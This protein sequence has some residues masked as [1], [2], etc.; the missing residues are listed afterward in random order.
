MNS[1]LLIL[2]EGLMAACFTFLADFYHNNN[3]RVD[4]GRDYDAVAIFPSLAHCRLIVTD[5]LEFSKTTY[6]PHP[7]SN[8]FYYH[9]QP[10]VSV[11]VS[12]T[13]N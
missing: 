9:L 13:E 8:V 2:Y 6:W 4:A 10:K 1:H 5:W 11:S 3:V 12:S 7:G